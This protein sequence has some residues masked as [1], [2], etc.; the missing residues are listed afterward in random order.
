MLIQKYSFDFLMLILQK[1][2]DSVFVL[3]NYLQRKDIDIAFA[4]QLIDVTRKKFVD[5]RSDE[6]FESLN[7]VA[8]SNHLL[9]RN[10]L[11]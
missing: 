11:N 2:L 8:L 1:L 6:S 5:M 4:K 3:Y 9:K 7:G 10:V